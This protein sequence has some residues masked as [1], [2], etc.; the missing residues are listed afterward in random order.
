MCSK[1]DD[2]EVDDVMA[3]KRKQYIEEQIFSIYP[4]F[5]VLVNDN[6]VWSEE[7]RPM[8]FHYYLEIAYC[9]EGKGIFKSDRQSFEVEE[10]D[11][12]IAAPNTLHSTCAEES[13]HTRWCNIYID[14]EDLLKLFP[15]GEARSQLRMIREAFS[16][17]LYLDSREYRDI[18]WPFLE[19]I[20]LNN[21]KKRNYKMQIMGLLYAM[22]FKIYEIFSDEKREER[23]TANLPIMPAV[24]YIYDHYMEPIKVA[25]L[26]G[27]CHFSESYFRKVFL[28]MK[29][30]GPMEYL[31]S[32][33]IRHAC[34]ML[35]NSTETIRMVGEKCG[36][37]SV[38]T[39]ERNFRQRMGMLPSQWRD[40]QR[41][42]RKKDRN[43]YEIKRIYYGE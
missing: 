29:G 8:H 11:I 15:V 13:V 31:N 12:T 43:D 37:P 23:S 4:D 16:D 41:N 10:G 33:R 24:E 20:R 35:Q 34:R 36:Y 32:I 17:I 39:F 30:M 18:L 26:A 3:K 1:K 42:V 9:F 6:V 5:P 7:E 14:M 25:D 40:S 19:I 2:K 28:E 27:L 21:E 38:T 22:L